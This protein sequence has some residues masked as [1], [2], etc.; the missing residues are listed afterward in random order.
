MYHLYI[1][2]DT[3]NNYKINLDYLEESRIESYLDDVDKQ[4]QEKCRTRNEQRVYAMI[5][6]CNYKLIDWRSALI[7]CIMNNMD[8]CVY[9]I[10]NRIRLFKFDCKFLFGFMCLACSLGKFDI[11]K[12]MIQSKTLKFPIHIHN[13]AILKIAIQFKQYDILNYLLR[14]P[15]FKVINKNV[16]DYISMNFNMTMYNNIATCSY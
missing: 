12:Y 8:R 13:N 6:N 1:I 3:N 4:F 14:N 15:A 9:E 2:K 10:F 11:V 7:E 5:A 16:Y